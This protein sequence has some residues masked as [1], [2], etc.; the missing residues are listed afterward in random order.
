MK[1][2]ARAARV[3]AVIAWIAV[4]VAAQTPPSAHPP[5]AGMGDEMRWARTLFV[6]FDQLEYGPAGTGRPIDGEMRAWY[7][8]A[9][10]RLWLRAQGE[11]A[12]VGR[13]ADGEVELLYGRL[14][15][16]F[17]DAVIGVHVDQHWGGAVPTRAL[18]TLGFQ[19]LA[20]YRLELE[21]TVYVSERGEIS[22]RLQ[23]A[24]PVLIT[25]RLI[26][27]PEAELNAA[28]QAVP[29]YAVRRGL[30]NYEA[31]L[32]LRYE[33][34]REVAPYIGWTRT[35]RFGVGNIRTES[36]EWRF[37]TGLRLWR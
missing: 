32:R 27:E 31:A 12:T 20:P 2:L 34:I 29:R 10:R 16:P 30:N 4:P 11:L 19:G 14:V 18:L 1:P 17:W 36:P 13:D 8:G 9:Y 25:Q 35:R 33:F 7:G 22:G 37:V 5:M 23:V 3:L 6:M 15:D 24:F 21:P 28:L 26:A